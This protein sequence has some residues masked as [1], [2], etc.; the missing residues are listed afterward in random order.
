MRYYDPYLPKLLLHMM[1]L[2]CCN[3]IPSAKYHPKDV[4]HN[5]FVTALWVKD[6][7][8]VCAFVELYLAHRKQ[9]CFQDF[10]A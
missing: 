3:S 5:H 9:A 7:L 1:D 4:V 2:Q 10:L 8:Y 6:Q